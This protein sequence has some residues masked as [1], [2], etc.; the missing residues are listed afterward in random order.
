VPAFLGMQDA[1]T[2]MRITLLA[3]GLNVVLNLI[4]MFP[5]KAR[6]FAL[7]TAIASSANFY[8]L[9][10][11]LRRHI[12]PLDGKEMKNCFVRILAAS[13]IMGVVVVLV[14]AGM[15]KI[16]DFSELSG[17]IITVLIGIGCG[18]FTFFIAAGI[19]KVREV[20][21]ITAAFHRKK[22]M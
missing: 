11:N 19:L 8:L 22:Q 4:L 10:H 5:L 6:G 12:G 21:E 1:K 9:L 20:A 13:L 7:A 16:V 18:I 14:T 15:K 3:T 17:K 2:P